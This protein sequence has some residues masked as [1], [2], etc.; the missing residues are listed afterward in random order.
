MVWGSKAPITPAHAGQEDEHNQLP[1]DRESSA[2]HWDRLLRLLVESANDYAIFALDP[3]GRI[4]SWNRGAQNIKGY[5][6]A[7]AIGQ[8]FSLFYPEEARAANY[9][10]Y[11]L[12]VAARDGR[13][14]E[15]GWRVRKDGSRFW[16]KVTITALYDSSGALLGFGKVTQDLT[17]RREAAE[18]ER[19][20]AAERAAHQEAMRR[21]EEL[22]LLNEQL[23]ENAVELEAQTAE[24]QLLMRQLERVNVRLQEA[25]RGA[26]K[27]R[28]DSEQAAAQA[29]EANRAKSDFLAVM[30]HEL[31][32]PLN[33]IA[34]YAELVETGIYGPV[35]ER[36]RDALGR[37]RQ[38]QRYLLSLINDVLN[39][40]KLE[41]GKVE[42]SLSTFSVEELFRHLDAMVTPQ[43]DTHQLRFA[44]N[45]PPSDLVVHADFEKVTQI[46]L[47]LLSNAIK[48]TEPRGI[49]EMEASRGEDGVLIAVHDSGIGIERDRLKAVF[50]PF[51]QVSRDLTS[52]HSG[53][54]LG[55]AISRDLARLM[56][57]DITVESEPGVGSTFTLLLR[58]E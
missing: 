57:G 51:V 5:S 34:G 1:A 4:L 24:A 13:H 31:R 28:V 36:Q 49:I 32:T 26:E 48:F 18:Q 39:F 52:M 40:A 47:N 29:A 54:G 55:L 2:A 56:G 50:E 35:T 53:T 15:E 22:S 25:L 3:H 9:P 30:S 27:A 14:E 33:A 8:H 19:R 41:A 7:E 38:S 46:M 37:I 12:E 45:K 10:D 11:E 43:L 21:S 6:A 20:L 16:A 17:R 58:T 44:R 42:L 23:E